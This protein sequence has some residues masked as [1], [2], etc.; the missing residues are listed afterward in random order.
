MAAATPNREHDVLQV[1][2]DVVFTLVAIRAIWKLLQGVMV[3]M[4]GD[5]GPRQSSVR[6]AQ[7]PPAQGVQMARD[8]ICGTYVVP[9]R[10]VSIRDGRQA[11]YFCSAACRDKYR[12]KTA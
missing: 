3:G 12:A 7:G 5:A 9:E 4:S 2:L 1:V 6:P 8:P 10:A 11:V